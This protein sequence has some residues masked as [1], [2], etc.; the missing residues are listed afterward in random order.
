MFA[1][2]YLNEYILVNVANV[3]RSSWLIHAHPLKD[4]TIT[5]LPI[6]STYASLNTYILT[7]KNAVCIK[8]HNFRYRPKY[9][10]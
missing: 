1:V 6:L 8:C 4:R 7:R 5:C 10:L 3:W 9:L 2:P